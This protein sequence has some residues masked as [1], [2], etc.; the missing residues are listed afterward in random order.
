MGVTYPPSTNKLGRCKNNAVRNTIKGQ[1]EVAQMTYKWLNEER[2]NSIDVA[3]GTISAPN[4][5]RG[6]DALCVPST[7]HDNV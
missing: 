4:S 3:R 6:E 7:S 5:R 1:V 2:Y